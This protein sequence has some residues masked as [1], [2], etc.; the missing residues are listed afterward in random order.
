MLKLTDIRR[1]ALSLPA[2][3]EAPHHTYSSFRVRGRIFVTIPPA[4][5]HIHIFVDEKARERA[6]ALDP[7]FLEKLLWGGKVVGLRVSLAAAMPAVVKGL[8]RAAWVRVAPTAL[9]TGISNPTR[10]G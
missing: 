6:L 4:Q 7:E 8:V 5:T 9:A 10:Q 2:V 3:T 1:Y